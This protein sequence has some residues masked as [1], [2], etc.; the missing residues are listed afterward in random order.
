MIDW[1]KMYRERRGKILWMSRH[2]VLESII[3]ARQ[4]RTSV[5][6]VALPETWRAYDIL[7]D[8][9]R[10]A[11]GFL[12]ISDEFPQIADPSIDP[13]SKEVRLVVAR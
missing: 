3:T 10:G 12:I 1:D 5:T 9:Q 11:F 4:D 8:F 6:R 2:E 13:G 7:F